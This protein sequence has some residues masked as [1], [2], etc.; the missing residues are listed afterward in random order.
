MN[1]NAISRLESSNYGKPTITTL[2]RLAA[3]MDVGLIVRFVPF[4]EMID[5]VSGTPRTVEG[6]TSIALTVPSFSEEENQCVFDQESDTQTQR[7]LAEGAARSAASSETKLTR[8][9]PVPFLGQP[10]PLGA[11]GAAQM[12]LTQ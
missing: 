2:K 5:W 4:S 12:H 8:S 1:Q 6:L 9:D 10:R 11:M 3:S 7:I